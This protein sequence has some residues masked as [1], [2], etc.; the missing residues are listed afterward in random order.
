MK[1]A[2]KVTIKGTVQGVF[3]RMFVKEKAD[4]LNLRG[5]V[6]NLPEGDVEALFEGNQEDIEKILQIIK[7]GPKHAYI[8]KVNT[9]EKTFSGDYKDFRILNF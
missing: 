3:F 8:K 2:I 5:F 6:R 9:E 4:E 1:K 7:Q